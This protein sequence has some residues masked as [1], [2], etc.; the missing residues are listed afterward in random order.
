MNKENDKWNVNSLPKYSLKMWKVS[1]IYRK[2]PT[3]VIEYKLFS[4][5]NFISYSVFSHI[6]TPLKYLIRYIVLLDRKINHTS[7]SIDLLKALATVCVGCIVR[8]FCHCHFS[9]DSVGD[10][11]LRRRQYLQLFVHF[12]PASLTNLHVFRLHGPHIHNG[13]VHCTHHFDR[14]DTSTGVRYDRWR[15]F[16]WRGRHIRNVPDCYI[17]HSDHLDTYIGYHCGKLNVFL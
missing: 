5:Y 17:L 16:R 7:F 2:S 9:R 8:Y 14:L 15:V 3:L 11:F 10:R 4:A 6:L 12:Y 1:K 13:P